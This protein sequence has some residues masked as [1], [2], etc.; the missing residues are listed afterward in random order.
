MKLTHVQN[1]GVVRI[2]DWKYMKYMLSIKLLF[3]ITLLQLLLLKREWA[4]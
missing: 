1:S 4:P 3:T 2:K